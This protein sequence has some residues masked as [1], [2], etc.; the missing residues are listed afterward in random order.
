M[1]HPS[2]KILKCS[3]LLIII[4][5]IYQRRIIFINYLGIQIKVNLSP[6]NYLPTYIISR[7]IDN[8]FYS[9]YLLKTIIFQSY[10]ECFNS[11]TKLSEFVAILRTVLYH[12]YKIL[13]LNRQIVF[14]IYYRL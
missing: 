7:I 11:I 1:I 2:Q 4:H 3:Y 12:L 5:N 8:W 9:Y 10:S 13:Y 14:N 6:L